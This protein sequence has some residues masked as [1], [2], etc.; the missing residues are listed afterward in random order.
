MSEQEDQ[1][2]QK[3]NLGQNEDLE[4]VDPVVQIIITDEDNSES[5]SI[6]ESRRTR[7]NSDSNASRDSLVSL[8]DETNLDDRGTIGSSWKNNTFG[9]DISLI[10]LNGVPDQNLVSESQRDDEDDDGGIT[11]VI[12]V[13]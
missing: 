12:G 6:R 4:H 11:M 3:R 7:K 5:S 9:S 10:D 2:E 13:G 1:D 8:I